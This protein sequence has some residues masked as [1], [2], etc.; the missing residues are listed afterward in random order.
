MARGARN[1]AQDTWHGAAAY[2]T[3]QGRTVSCLSQVQHARCRGSAFV[4]GGLALGGLALG[5]MALGGMALGGMAL[6]CTR[7]LT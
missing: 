1:A 4:Q 6:G 2:G 3:W 5:C 7:G